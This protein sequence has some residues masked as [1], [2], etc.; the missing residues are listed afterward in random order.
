MGSGTVWN[1]NVDVVAS[2]DNARGEL[3]EDD[4][5]THAADPVAIT[6]T[7]SSAVTI[8]GVVLGVALVEA[9]G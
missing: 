9:V 8:V 6:C 5:G 1:A 7:P 4:R 3:R 2:S